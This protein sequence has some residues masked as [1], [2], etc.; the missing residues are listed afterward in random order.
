MTDLLKGANSFVPS[1]PLR[2][3]VMQGLNASVLLVTAQGRVRGGADLVFQGQPGHPSGA[4]R[5]LG[6]HDGADWLQVDLPAVEAGVDRIVIAASS[7]GG[8]LGTAAPTV[9]AF[10]PDGTMVVRY[11][12]IDATT[13]TACVLG[14]FYRRAG[15]WKFRAVGQGWDDGLAGLAADH[16]LEAART[17]APPPVPAPIPPQPFPRSAAP[18]A[19]AFAALLRHPAKTGYEAAAAQVQQVQQLRSGP[20]VPPAPAPAAPTAPGG[21][22]FGAEFQPYAVQERGSQVVT[23][24]SNVPPGPVIVE[25]ETSGDDYICVYT[26]DDRNKDADLLVNTTLRDPRHR[27]LAVAPEG[28]RLRIRVSCERRWTLKVLPLSAAALLDGPLEGRGDDVVRYTGPLADLVFRAKTD[29]NVTVYGY[30]VGDGGTELP[31]NDILLV[32]EIGK[33]RSSSPMPPGPLLLK[34]SAD[35]TWT[36]RARP[37]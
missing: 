34:L 8:P 29:S 13:E 2:V 9:A 27:A 26:L 21:W 17:G 10:A 18:V 4:V 33:V 7:G 36:M 23:V 35:G 24:P 3:G 19:P 37:V 1:V 30:E 22:D 5:H 25:F 11:A 14:E 15:G 31:E 16:G 32:N 12:L 28:R 20:P 6:P